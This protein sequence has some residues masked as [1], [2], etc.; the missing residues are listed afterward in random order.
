MTCALTS[1]QERPA[2]AQGQPSIRVE[3]LERSHAVPGGNRNNDTIPTGLQTGLETILR[4]TLEFANRYQQ[5]GGVVF[6][7]KPRTVLKRAE[8]HGQR[9]QLAF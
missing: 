9:L 5:V 6:V 8:L 7:R 4:N 1:P 2:R 3:H